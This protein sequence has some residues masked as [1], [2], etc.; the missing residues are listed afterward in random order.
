LNKLAKLPGLFSV[1]QTSVGTPWCNTEIAI[2]L[3]GCCRNTTNS[4]AIIA[5]HVK[6]FEIRSECSV[7]ARDVRQLEMGGLTAEQAAKLPGL[8]S[9]PQTSVGT[10][11][12]NTEIAILLSGCCRNT[13]N[14]LAIIAKHVKPFEIRSECSVIARDLNKLAKLPGL[15]SVPQTSVGTPWCNTEIAILLSGCCRNTTNSLAIIAKHV[16]LSK[17][18]QS[19]QS[20]LGTNTTNSLAIIA[21]HVK[22]FEIRSECSVIARDLNKLAKLPG[23][24]SVP[25]TS[26]GTPWCNTEIAILL[27]GCCRNTTNSLAIIAKHVKPFEIRS[28]CSVIA[29]DLNKLAKLPGLFSVPQTSVGTPW[30]N[31]EIAILLSGCCR[32]TTNSLAIIA[33]HVKPFEIRSECSVIARD[34]NK[35]AKLPGLFSVPQ[36]SVGTPWCNTE[37]A[38]LLSGCCRNT[39]NSLAI[40]AKHVKPFEI[41]SECSVIAR[42]VRQLEMGGLTA[43]QAGKIAWTVLCPT[44]K[45]GLRVFRL[46]CGGA[47]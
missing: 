41:R 43:E 28:E 37:I 10:P 1:P 6:P 2:L 26:V 35:L 11:W 25:Q 39:T 29:R 47:L 42:D 12:C 31:T 34:L 19:A 17:F 40:I 4:L 15:F 16:N 22:P 7:I 27:S 38:I 5:K 32:N 8:F 23:L 13:T 14:S 44:N 33:K 3:S 21:K 9:V 36:T 30:C 46:S 45:C 24:F 20:S 18:A